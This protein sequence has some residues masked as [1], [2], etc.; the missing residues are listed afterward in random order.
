MP[1]LVIINRF[2]A[3]HAYPLGDAFLKLGYQVQL[4]PLECV[5]ALD[6]LYVN[7]LPLQADAVLW[8][9]GE[10]EWASAISLLTACEA[11]GIKTLNSS[12]AIAVCANKWECHKQLQQSGLRSVPSLLVTPGTK[13]TPLPYRRII[14][15]VFGAGG[16]GIAEIAAGESA[17]APSLSLLQTHLGRWENFAR[18]NVVGGHSL[19]GMQR[20]APQ[21]SQVNNLERGGRPRAFEVPAEAEE[22]AIA[23]AAAC[24]A[25]I[26]A[27]DVVY[28]EG[29]WWVLEINSSPGYSGMVELKGSAYYH[30]LSAAISSLFV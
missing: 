24:G 16:E 20:Q 14:K 5:T 17:S 18:V 2:N 8:R 23:A 9:V 19:G 21:G 3:N 26:S 13:I 12:Q 28:W 15:P 6:G 29:E 27:V 1:R 30:R 10:S 25:E 11:Q 7:D 22:L 4:C